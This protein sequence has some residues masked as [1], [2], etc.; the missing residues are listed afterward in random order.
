MN[1][2][3]SEVQRPPS[4]GLPAEVKWAVQAAQ[5]KKAIDVAVL[6]LRPVAAFTDFFVICS[7][8]SPRQVTAI[9]EA[10]EAALAKLRVKPAHVEGY[11]RADWILLDYF[12]F[13]VHIFNPKTRS[14]YG[15]ERLW[16]SAERIE[17]MDGRASEQSRTATS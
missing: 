13:V 17:V 14:F 2:I 6:D 8:Q 12:Q 16:G 11:K 1:D 7:G 4:A 3:S 9:A 10:V 5:D 15:L